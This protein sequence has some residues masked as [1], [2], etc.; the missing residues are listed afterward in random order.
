MN[1]Q[2]SSNNFSNMTTYNSN[3]YRRMHRNNAAEKA[4]RTFKDHLITII[5][6]FDPKFLMHLWCRLVRQA[7]TTLNLLHQ[8]HVNLRLSAEAQLN[9]AYGYNKPTLAPPGTRIIVYEIPGKRGTWAPHGV[10]GWHISSAP[11]HYRCHT[12]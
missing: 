5:C 12:T 11:E 3:L 2:N 4:I 1:V 9:G 8:S 7:T 10:D 6:S